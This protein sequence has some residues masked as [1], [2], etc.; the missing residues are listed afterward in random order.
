MSNSE[1]YSEL[2]GQIVNVAERFV[3]AVV[4]VSGSQAGLGDS[5]QLTPQ[6]RLLVEELN[7]RAQELRHALANA[8]EEVAKQ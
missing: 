2:A 8:L 7:D 6:Q 4:W 1:R 3:L 5:D